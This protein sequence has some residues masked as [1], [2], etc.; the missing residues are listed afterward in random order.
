M[1]TSSIDV[2][3][4]TI[5]LFLAVFFWYVMFLLRPFNFWAEMAGATLF[6]GGVGIYRMGSTLGFRRLRTPRAWALGIG[7]ALVLYLIFLLGKVL[8]QRIF[9][10]SSEEISII[11]TYRTEGNPLVVLLL[12]LFLIGPCEEIYWRG[13]VQSSLSSLLGKFQGFLITSLFYGLIHL[14]AGNLMLFL[15]A[16]VCGLSWGWLYQKQ[17]ELAPVIIS[18]A[19]WD[20]LIFVILPVQ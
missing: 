17:R 20:A 5:S 7:S 15:A 4:L 3:F 11:Y 14:W 18:H 19:L 10:F 6:L 16:L 12:L 13:F 1:K 2:W 9:P 8:S